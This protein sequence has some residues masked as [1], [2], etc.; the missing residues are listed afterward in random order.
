MRHSF[1]K[2]CVFHSEFSLHA[3]SKFKTVSVFSAYLIILCGIYFGLCSNINFMILLLPFFRELKNVLI[4]DPDPAW[5]PYLVIAAETSFV[6]SRKCSP[7]QFSPV[8]SRSCSTRTI[9]ESRVILSS[10][11]RIKT[12][13]CSVQK[14]SPTERWSK[15]S[16]LLRPKVRA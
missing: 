13:L 12:I 3:V 4:P 15:V 7:V 16:L 6:R 11:R 2:K 5:V 1:D 10:V 14:C 9:L 8:A